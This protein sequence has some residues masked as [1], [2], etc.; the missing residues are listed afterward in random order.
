MSFDPAAFRLQF[1]LLATDARLHYLDNAATAQLHQT[2]LERLIAHETL[3]R[4]NVERGSYP[5][6]EHA[7][8]AYANAR[9]S[10]RRFLNAARAEEVVFTSGTTASINIFAQAFGARLAP[11]DEIVVSAAEHHSNF[12]PW[13]LLRD[14]GGARLRMLPRKSVV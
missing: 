6:A 2:V 7:S 9:A 5:L 8:E 13:Q 3:A 12:V 10:V 4:A 1:P 14:R 11:G